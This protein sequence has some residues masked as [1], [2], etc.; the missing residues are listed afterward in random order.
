M[1]SFTKRL[2]VF[3]ILNSVVLNMAL[4]LWRH[5]AN[6]LYYTYGYVTGIAGGD[7]WAPM[8]RAL[9]NFESSHGSQSLY[10]ELYTQEAVKFQYPP[11]SLLAIQALRSEDLPSDRFLNAIAWLAVAVTALLIAAISKL[12]FES[13]PRVFAIDTKWRYAVLL[14]FAGFATVTFYPVVKAY[15][16]GQAQTWINLLFPAAVLLYMTDRKRASGAVCGIICAIKPQLGLLLVWGLL[17]KEWR[18]SI[19]L[20]A[21]AAVVGSISLWI[22]G[23]NNHVAYLQ[24]LSFLSQHGEGFYGNQSVNGLLNRMLGNGNNLV[25]DAHGFPPYNGWVYAGTLISSAVIIGLALFWRSGD[26]RQAEVVDFVIAALSFTVA[27]PIAWEHHY[28]IMLPMFA[29]ALPAVL[30]LPEP[31]S[32]SLLLLAVSYVL[33]SNYYKLA[34]ESAATPFNFLQ[35]YLFLGAVLLLILLYHLR[36]ARYHAAEVRA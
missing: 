25:W 33:S 20:A 28:G 23:L 17:R 31:R 32:G 9:R 26:H 10:A 29:I 30:K 14:A 21:A 13:P 7:S 3:L 11:T 27:S 6:T 5:E 16:L 15:N 18:F 22:Y 35:S 19:G 2:A 24:V 8:R 34:N 1:T 4:F 12:T 36:G